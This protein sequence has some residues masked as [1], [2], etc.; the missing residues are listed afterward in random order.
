MNP[1]RDPPLPAPENDTIVAN[2]IKDFE[3]KT[4][5][6]VQKLYESLNASV[7]SL[8][9]FS[10]LYPHIPILNDEGINVTL[11]ERCFTADSPYRLSYTLSVGENNSF[12]LFP[13]DSGYALEI[14]CDGRAVYIANKFYVLAGRAYFGTKRVREGTGD[15]QETSS[16]IILPPR[17]SHIPENEYCKY[18][19]RA[20]DGVLVNESYAFDPDLYNERQ[21]VFTYAGVPWLKKT[22][23][24]TGC[25]NI[26]FR[27]IY[28]GE[29]RRYLLDTEDP[30]VFFLE[31][32]F[33]YLH[34]DEVDETKTVVKQCRSKKTVAT[35]SV[36]AFDVVSCNRYAV[37]MD[38]N[39]FK[40]SIFSLE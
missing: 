33:Y 34:E 19:Y 29:I 21:N 23:V 25:C 15:Y 38:K 39:G 32:E 17:P 1:A 10:V 6:Q 26:I 13:R 3:N 37:I 12:F 20:R 4:Q 7:T 11:R 28:T 16:S 2:M 40:L 14:N 18:L 31:D 27:N 22:L 5:D 35:L 36:K 8:R 9:G 24:G 30:F